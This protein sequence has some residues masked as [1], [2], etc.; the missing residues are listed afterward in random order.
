MGKCGI[1]KQVR[2]KVLKEE[3][4]CHVSGMLKPAK[5]K[6][7]AGMEADKNFEVKLIPNKAFSEKQERIFFLE[8]FILE[9]KNKAS[10][11][12]CKKELKELLKY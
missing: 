7:N 3:N 1:L 5:C 11:K 12:A 8:K 2:S 10:V 4:T 6:R 9:S